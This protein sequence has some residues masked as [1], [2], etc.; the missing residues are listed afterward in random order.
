MALSDPRIFFGVHSFTPYNRTNGMPYGTALVVGNSSFGLSG[1]LSKL[2]GGSNKY[3]WAIEETNIAAELSLTFKQYEDWMFE[4]F[5]GKAPT[6][7]TPSATGTV[8]TITNKKG[9]SVVDATTGIASI[10]A[11]G[12]SEDDLKF[13]KYAVIAASATTVDVYAYSNVDF[14]RG[15][16]ADFENDLLKITASP[17]TIPGTD[18]TVEVPKFGLTLTGGS[19]S[20]A[21]T[22]G[23]TA[24]FEVLP[25]DDSSISATFGGSA[26]TFPTFGAILMGQ[27]RGNGQMVELDVYNIKAVGL[28]IG[29]QEKAFSEAEVTAQ[30]FYDASK[31]G[32]FEM[33]VVKPS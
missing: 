16:D 1:E 19:G 11:T 6:A 18:G 26:D 30:A 21:M 3:P 33:R 17:L 25:P 28:P 12:S 22:E 31:N 23:D 9:T 2:L 14:S 24:T 20:I 8:S 32:V 27:Q 5:L 15:E 7:G 29:L 13:S 10:A 4:L